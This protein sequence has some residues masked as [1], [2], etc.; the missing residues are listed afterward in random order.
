M[1]KFSRNLVLVLVVLV[2]VSALFALF[3][4]P[5]RNTESITITQLKNDINEDLVERIEITGTDVKVFY[6]AGEE[7]QTTKEAEGILSEA[8]I[9]LNVDQEKLA[10]VAIEPKA[11]SGFASFIGPLTFLLLPV[12][13][14]LVFFWF[15]FRQARSGI[16]QAF[17]FTRTRAKLFGASGELKTPITF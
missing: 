9:D 2:F 14:L 1:K 12:L 16:G 4:E 13:L 3:G 6:K 17:D 10:G 11:P 8:L 5:F 7:K 15:M